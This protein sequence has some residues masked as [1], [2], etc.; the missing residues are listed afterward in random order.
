RTP[1]GLKADG[2]YVVTQAM[3]SGLSARRATPFKIYRVNYSISSAS[4]TSAHCI[5]YPVA[6]NQLGKQDIVFARAGE[7]LS[8]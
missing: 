5:G 4:A 3:A 8:W 1:R 2:P 7:E 6:Q